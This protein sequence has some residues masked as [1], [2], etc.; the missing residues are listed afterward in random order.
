M[1]CKNY[2]SGL[3][4]YKFTKSLDTD[5]RALAMVLD[6]PETTV[7]YRAH[8]PINNTTYARSLVEHLINTVT[9]ADQVQ[10]GLN[11]IGR[12]DLSANFFNATTEF[13]I[14]E[15][16]KHDYNYLQTTCNELPG[17]IKWHLWNGLILDWKQFATILDIKLTNIIAHADEQNDKGYAYALIRILHGAMIPVKTVYEALKRTHHNDLA[18]LFMIEK[19]D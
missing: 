8:T 16:P 19:K 9:P 17:I 14:I 5:W 10:K 7:K 13:E 1:S 12:K 15:I 6:I 18:N 4:L 3:N 2:L 11:T